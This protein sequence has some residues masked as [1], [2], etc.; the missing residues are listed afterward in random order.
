[1]NGSCQ[2]FYLLI[3]RFRKK[4]GVFVKHGHTFISTV[5]DVVTCFAKKDA[6]VWPLGQTNIAPC[7]KVA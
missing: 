1:M 6:V 3:I 7:K 5:Q 4:R 2:A